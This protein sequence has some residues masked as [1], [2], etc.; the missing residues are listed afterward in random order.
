[1]RYPRYP[2]D[3]RRFTLRLDP[4]LRELLVAEARRQMRCLNSEIVIRL[5]RSVK[6]HRGSAAACADAPNELQEAT[7][8]HA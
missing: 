8:R 3:E 4:D 5:K 1:M 2:S 7:E 6:R